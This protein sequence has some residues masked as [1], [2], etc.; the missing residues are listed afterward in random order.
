MVKVHPLLE[1]MEIRIVKD[2]EMGYS[3][4]FCSDVSAVKVYSRRKKKPSN[5]P[6]GA[7]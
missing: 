3:S 6:S 5:G 4:D 7:V 1:A 2:Q